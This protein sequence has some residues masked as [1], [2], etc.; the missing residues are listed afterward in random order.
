MSG[1]PVNE[2]STGRVL[3]GAPNFR[4]LGGLTTVD[5]HIIRSGV[6]F[7]SSGF[8]ELTSA[9]VAYLVDE[10]GLRTVFDLRS[11]HDQE[12][13]QP[14]AGMGVDV[15]N[16]PIERDGAP[17][18]ITRPMRPDGRVDI[19]LV[20]T[21]LLNTSVERFAEIIH[22]LVSG[23][24]PAVFHCVSGKD[25]TGVLGA[26]VLRV[27]GVHDDDIVADYARSGGA[28]VAMAD[29]VAANDPEA[30]EMMRQWPAHFREAPEETMRLF[31]ELF[32]ARHGSVEAFLDGHGVG[33]PVLDR[34]RGDLIE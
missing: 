27:L 8:E 12:I 29:W 21:M 22:R 2:Q 7:R 10:V 25:R 16:I 20:Y 26:F 9:D 4:D 1:T 17:T 31:L 19:P 24:T 23:A 15:V 14:L 33:S 30:A 3:T 28:M 11:H 32:D 34:L 5:G 18:D 6:L 13:A